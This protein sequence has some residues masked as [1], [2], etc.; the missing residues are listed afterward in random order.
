MGTQT[1]CAPSKHIKFCIQC[2]KWTRFYRCFCYYTI[3][4]NFFSFFYA[5]LGRETPFQFFELYESLEW[6]RE[7]CRMT[8]THQ[9]EKNRRWVE[10]APGTVPIPHYECG[11]WTDITE[12][13]LCGYMA[14]IIHLHNCTTSIHKLWSMDDLYRLPIAPHYPI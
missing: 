10:S 8:N 6:R 7:I 12:P 1:S 4:F 14:I 13:E 11:Y 9:E 3:V 5:I 2:S